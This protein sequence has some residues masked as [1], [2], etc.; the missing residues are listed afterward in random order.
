PG[1]PGRLAPDRR[2]PF[3]TKLQIA[4]QQL[5]WAKTWIGH[6]FGKLWVMVDG[7]YAKRPFLRPVRQ[8]GCTVVSRLRKDAALWSAPVPVKVNLLENSLKWAVHSGVRAKY[9]AETRP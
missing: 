2:R 8:L 3:R 1:R 4:A 6:R 7:A 9:S 5:A